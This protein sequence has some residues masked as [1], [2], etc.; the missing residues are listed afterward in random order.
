MNF[1]CLL[2]CSLS[3]CSMN[4]KIL[5]VEDNPLDINIFQQMLGHAKSDI[6]LILVAMNLQEALD[7]LEQSTP[8]ILFLDLHLPDS[9]GLKTFEVIHSAYPEIPVVILTGDEDES[10]A[11]EAI[12]NG[13]QDY[14][15]KKDITPA[16]IARSIIYS[17]ERKAIEKQLLHSKANNDALI[18]NTKDS[19]W[20]VDS[21]FNY[22]TINKRFCESFELLTGKRPVIGD[23]MRASLPGAYKDWFAEIFRR[24]LNG[25]QFRVETTLNFTDTRHD[26]ELS[27]NPIRSNNQQINGVS[28]FA[29]N[30]DQRKRDEK[31]IRKSEHAYRLLL[32]T[33]NEGVMFVDNDGLVQ[34]AN[35]KFIETTG[36]EETELTGKRFGDLLDKNDPFH[37]KNIVG[38]LLNDMNPVEIHFKSKSGDVVW[39]KVKGT[40]LLDDTGQIGGT[41]LT[42]TEITAQKQAEAT[43][44]KREQDYENLLE[45]MN[46]GL[47]YIHRSGLVKFANKR[48]LEITGFT[49]EDLTGKKVP[50]Q[51]FP[52]TLLELIYEESGTAK[53]ETNAACQYEIQIH[54]RNSQRK[55]CMINCSVTRDE[56]GVLTGILVTY[57][58]ITDRKSTEEKLQLA[59]RELN[60][61]IY[62]S[63]HDLKGPLSSILG[64]IQLLEKE[65]EGNSATPCVNMIRHSAE[66]LDRML[67]EL[68]NV[69]RIKREKIYPEQINFKTELDFVLN[70]FESTSGFGSI[71]KKISVDTHKELRTDKKLLSS[72]LHNLIDN[73]IRY[74][75]NCEDDFIQVHIHDFM[76]GVKI[77][78]TDN[79][80]GFDEKTRG[81]IFMMFN[82]GNNNSNGNGLGLYVVKNA[83]DR[84][85]GY[86]EVF[87]D[88]GSFTRFTVFLPDLFSTDQWAEK[89]EVFN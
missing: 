30:I 70:A 8:D 55:W 21:D 57:S 2:K 43:I 17:K 86:I 23:N 27:V 82:K 25:E 4:Q 51:L 37:G 62:K 3:T 83:I 72:V 14:L 38:E 20:A 35:R 28:F 56:T 50:Y 42:H 84:L 80:V 9:D 75:K 36:F 64:L 18:E 54:T 6:G 63:S 46:E 88:S 24:A 87:A 10:K 22:I 15:M 16:L 48:F 41:L 77:E 71:C 13:A 58:D 66:K 79:G 7:S 67:N 11:I 44:R 61:F 81:N 76:H 89:Q 53:S 85:G 29:R 31:R 59:Q 45:T 68:L 78:I 65:N 12:R 1:D 73:A 19:I 33:I 69:V 74:R 49:L 52:E 40:P 26:I 32:E 5:L 34:F 60:T 47:L 39:F